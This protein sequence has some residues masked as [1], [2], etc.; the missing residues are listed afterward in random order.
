MSKILESIQ[1]KFISEKTQANCDEINFFFVDYK[2]I[3]DE[4]R[5][6]IKNIRFFSIF[7]YKLIVTRTRFN[8][9]SI[10]GLRF[11]YPNSSHI[12]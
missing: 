6:L 9:F 5:Q 8:N 10:A 12:K 11:C 4:D 7:F 3:N 2:P 1:E